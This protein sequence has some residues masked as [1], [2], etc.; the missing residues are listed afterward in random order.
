MLTQATAM[1]TTPAMVVYPN[2]VGG[3]KAHMLTSTGRW[4]LKA[5]SL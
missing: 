2:A 1:Q 4:A 5:H 3:A